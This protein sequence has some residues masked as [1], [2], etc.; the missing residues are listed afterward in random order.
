MHDFLG[1]LG[2]R[3]L[4]LFHDVLDVGPEARL[5]ASS[6]RASTSWLRAS[7]AVRLASFS[8][9]STCEERNRSA[10]SRRLV[11]MSSWAARS[12]LSVS[13][14]ASLRLVC[15]RALDRFCSFCWRPCSRCL[16]LFSLVMMICFFLLTS[17]SNSAFSLRYFSLASRM[18]SF[19]RFSA[20]ISAS[21]TISFA[22]SSASSSCFL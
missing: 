12:S 19:L 15:S 7:S 20:V 22:F 13:S 4:G 11:A 17:S 10:S 6:L 8:S 1:F 18:R 2:G 9:F 21:F 5:W 14:S 3:E 16:S